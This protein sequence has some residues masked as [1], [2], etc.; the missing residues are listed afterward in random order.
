MPTNTL[1]DG[2]EIF[3]ADERSRIYELLHLMNVGFGSAV[4][5]IV[6]AATEFDVHLDVDVMAEIEE[7]TREA[8]SEA[9]RYMLERFLPMECGDRNH[10]QELRK[11]RKTKLPDVKRPKPNGR[12]APAK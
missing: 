10:F 8:Q 2:L 3:S 12:K 7:L 1:S 6:Q 5:C 11:G 9:N 4:N